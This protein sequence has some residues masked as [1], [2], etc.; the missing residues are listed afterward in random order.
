[1]KSCVIV[2]PASNCDRDGAVA[3][4]QATG[5]KPDMVWHQETELP[6][7]DFILLPGGFSY[8]DYL[9]SGAMAARSPIVAD[10]IK[11]AEA[12]TLVLGICNG[13][14][15]LTET[16]LLPGALMRNAGLDFICGMQTLQVA[17]SDSQF[18]KGL[19]N[20]AYVDFPVAHHDGNYTAD[21]ETLNKLEGEGRVAFRYVTNPNGSARN[22][23]GILN[24]KGN[25]LGMMP[26]PERVISPLLGGEDGTQFFKGIIEAIS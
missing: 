24:E 8:G 4:E 26:H 2:F 14:Q 3:L 6:D 23:A 17:N 18:T 11:K 19:G 16:G 10:V 12:G 15:V 5:Q 25:V 13:F 20:R 9:R 21:D 7:T 1:M 22:I